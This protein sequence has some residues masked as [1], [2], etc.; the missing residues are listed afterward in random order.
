MFSG[1]MARRSVLFIQKLH[2]N[3]P[4]ILLVRTSIQALPVRRTWWD[5]CG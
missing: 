4:S 5:D 2:D 1:P 3:V